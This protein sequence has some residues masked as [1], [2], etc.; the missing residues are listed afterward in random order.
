MHNSIIISI[1]FS[2]ACYAYTPNNYLTLLRQTES[3]LERKQKLIDKKLATYHKPFSSSEL[4]LLQEEFIQKGQKEFLK[5]LRIKKVQIHQQLK[6]LKFLKTSAS[7]ISST[8]EETVKIEQFLRTQK[9]TDVKNKIDDIV[10]LEEFLKEQQSLQQQYGRGISHN[11]TLASLS[12]FWMVKKS[13]LLS[14]LRVLQID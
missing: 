9:A 13:Y 11:D 6:E 1:I 7:E 2:S 3:G 5:Q 4:D 14:E 8:E 10:F 12:S